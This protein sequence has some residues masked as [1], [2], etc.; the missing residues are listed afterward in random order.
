MINNCGDIRTERRGKAT[1][2][3]KTTMAMVKKKQ[4]TL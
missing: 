2:A 3:T 4:I 1:T